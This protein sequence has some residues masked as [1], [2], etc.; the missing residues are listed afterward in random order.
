[1]SKNTSA[2]VD[3]YKD[4]QVALSNALIQAKKAKASLLENKLELL[5]IYKL[6]DECKTVIKKD[7]EGNNYEVHA[8]TLS[9]REVKRLTDHKGGGVYTQI[10]E[11]A[12][13]LKKKIFI[14][15]EPDKNRFRMDNLYGEVTYDRGKLTIEFNPATEY[16]FTELQ[17]NFTKLNLGI[18]FNL[19]HLGSFQ[20]Y[21]V[22]KPQMYILPDIELNRSQEEQQSISKEYNLS[23]LRLQLGY[24]DLEQPDIKKEGMKAHPDSEKMAELEK[25]PKYKRWNDFYNRIIAPGVE[26]I[27]KISDIY[28]SDIEPRK[29]AHGK[30]ESVIFYCQ[31][32]KEYYK[33]NKK[34]KESIKMTE[35]QI[36]DFID[37]IR[38]LL[39]EDFKT[40]DLKAI[41]EASEYDKKKIL[42][43]YGVLKQTS[44][45]NN[46]PG[47]MIDAI[48]K[49]YTNTGKST[50]NKFEQRK[51]DY[52]EL[53]R[54]AL[55]H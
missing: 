3:V 51:Y 28:I 21:K 14:Y 38:P 6:K 22:L 48:K 23:E 30:I 36:D 16:L 20:L 49:G 15:A 50:F 4:K 9:T 47:F 12:V 1:M 33:K 29:G 32:N 19:S 24:V 43:A 44:N 2:E 54:E 46:A 34:K 40:K 26:E 10:A 25:K 39:D 8:V 5:G 45:I 52:E 35:E 27:N 31:H 11:A 7:A 37:E 53:E 18:A 17:N 42:K 13:E 41:A 55:N